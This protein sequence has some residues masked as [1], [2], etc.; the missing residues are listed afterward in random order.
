MGKRRIRCLRALGVEDI[1]GCDK[2]EDRCRE[3]QEL[4]NIS[5]VKWDEILYFADAA[6]VCTPPDQHIGSAYDFDS[7]NI[8]FFTEAG[9]FPM[10]DLAGHPSCTMRFWAGPR[11]VKTAVTFNSIGRPLSFVYHVGQYLPDWHPYEDYR[12]FYVSKRTT[13]AC[14]EIVPFE[15]CWLTWCFGDVVSVTA[16]K[17]KLS[18]LDADID[19]VYQLLLA[20]ESGVQGVLQVDVLAHKAT[21]HFHLVGSEDDIVMDIKGDESY[22][23]EETRAFLDAV[24]GNAT[25]PYTYAD[26]AKVLRVLTAAELSAQG[27]HCVY[28]D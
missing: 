15:L 1:Q 22:Y 7:L 4:Y 23:V 20:F 21:R 9:V 8:P 13:G 25:W 28:L 11:Q 5:I 12:T 24:Q 6:F 27:G 10:P 26:E 2:R 17:G 19:D 16:Y 3:A 18:D 14:R